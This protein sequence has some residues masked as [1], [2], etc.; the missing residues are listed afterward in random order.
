M[1]LYVAWSDRGS[2]Q[3]R[4][5]S[6][7]IQGIRFASIRPLSARFCRSL[8][9]TAGPLLSMRQRRL[10]KN[11]CPARHCPAYSGPVTPELALAGLSHAGRDHKKGTAST[12]TRRY[13]VHDGNPPLKVCVCA[14]SAGADRVLAE[15]G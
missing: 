4:C 3:L 15:I 12:G 11:S 10:A 8:V 1:V 5:P 9:A 6:S 14:T 7:G 13:V 2:V